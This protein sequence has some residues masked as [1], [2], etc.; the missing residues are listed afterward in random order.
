MNLNDIYVLLKYA[1]I[2]GNILFVLWITYNGIDEGF[3][4]TPYQLMSYFGLTILLVLN[5]VLLLR[6]DKEE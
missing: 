4:A 6:K 1:A 5:T 2:A 3:K